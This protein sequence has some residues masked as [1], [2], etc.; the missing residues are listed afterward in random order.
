MSQIDQF[1]NDIDD[2]EQTVHAIIGFINFYRWDDA[3]KNM[4]N[5]TYVFQGMRLRPSAEHGAAAEL[6]GARSVTP[7]IAI[8]RHAQS[9]VVAEVKKSFPADS[10]H[11][12]DDF[13]QLMA[14]DDNLEGWPT[15]NKRVSSHD[16]VLLTHQSRAVAVKRFQE[17]H[18]RTIKFQRPFVIVEFNRSDERQPYFFFRKVRGTLTEKAVDDRLENGVQIPMS[19]FARVYSTVKFY[20]TAPPIPYMQSLIWTHVVLP[21]AF[22]QNAGKAGSLR[23]NRKLDVILTV[24]EIADQLCEAFSYRRLNDQHHELQPQIPKKEWVIDACQVLVRLKEAEWVDSKQSSITI[25]FRHYDDILAHF[26]ESCASQPEENKEQLPLFG[27]TAT[28]SAA[29]GASLNPPRHPSDT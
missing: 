15:A 26:I 17:E 25:F 20:D 28:P 2:Y 7:D 5:D 18:S 21:A 23:K 4:R 10:R 22:E 16:I 3:T 24:D 29:D 6:N 14:Y 1:K 12:H 13:N 9:C 8:F 19:V 11:W 27:S